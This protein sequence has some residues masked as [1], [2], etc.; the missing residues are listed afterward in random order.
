[1]IL[2]L[3]LILARAPG[4]ISI[5]RPHGLIVVLRPVG[6]RCPVCLLLLG[7]VFRRRVDFAGVASVGQV[8]APSTFASHSSGP[9]PL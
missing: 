1:M 8:M 4:Q 9:G 7:V 6:S 3:F 2:L 5:S